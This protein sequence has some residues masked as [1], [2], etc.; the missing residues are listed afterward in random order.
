MSVSSPR[1]SRAYRAFIESLDVDVVAYYR[2][3][4]IPP[5]VDLL[6][7]ASLRG[8]P[9]AEALAL[10]R[11]K[12]ADSP[13]AAEALAAYEAGTLRPRTSRAIGAV[14]TFAR[15][16]SDPEA[17]HGVKATYGCGACGHRPAPI[18]GTNFIASQFSSSVH[19]VEV[20]CPVCRSFT[21]YE[22]PE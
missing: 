9:L 1:R 2:N 6:A 17:I 3:D 8:R 14:A 4:Q 12:A 18:C 5:E 11:A 21:V 22:E 10:F 19:Q 15:L 20:S 16:P 7:L 13:R